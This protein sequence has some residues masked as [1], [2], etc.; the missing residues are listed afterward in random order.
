MAWLTK[1]RFMS[2]LQC[3]KRLWMEV[4]EPLAEPLP[5]SAAFMNGRAVDRLVQ[6]LQ[7]GPVISRERGMPAAIAETARVLRGGVPAVLYQPAFR[8]GDLAVIADVLRSRER[9]ITLTEVKSSTA[10]KPEHLPDAG[11]QAYVL[12]RCRV[13][14][15]RVLLAHVDSRFVLRQRGDYD[16]LVIEQDIT[17]EVEAA[18]PEIED[19]AARLLGVMASGRRPTVAMGPQCEQPYQCPFIGRCTQELGRRP[20]YPVQ[21]LPHGGRIVQRLVDAGFDDL[22][23]VPAERLSGALHRRVHQATLS[24]EPFFDPAAA[25]PLRALQFPMAY[26]DFE[27]LGLAVPEII[28]TRPY[29]QLPFQWSLHVEESAASVRHAEYLAAEAFGDQ[30]ALARALLA[31][32]PESGPVFAYNARFENSVLQALAER[33]PAWGNALR[34]LAGRLVDLLPITRAAYYHRDMRGSWSLK[35]VLP[36]IDSTL[37]Y[38]NM[39]EVR[40]GEQ[41]QLA[42]MKLLDAAV[43][44]AEKQRLALAL[45][46]YCERDTWA[47]VVLR[48]FL[49]GSADPAAGR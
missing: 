38:A 32:V 26:L 37:D 19:A 27:T 36:T 40:E 7:P 42:Y 24:G 49:C 45:R 14:V 6:T 48:R 20:D 16:G 15:D 23:T 2:G 18:L 30:Q 10:V 29:E 11:F 12:R 47:L 44:A 13:A 25:A 8:S 31:A 33:V 17:A 39:D 4:N 21:L 34:E 9:S 28:G 5:D 1:S 46:R 35:A 3:P 41:A 43:D 22:R